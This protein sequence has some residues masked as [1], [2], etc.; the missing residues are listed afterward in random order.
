MAT[1]LLGFNPYGGGTVLDISS[2]P[3]QLYIQNEQHEQAK[4][5]ALDKYF[6]DYE[7]T[8]N[9]AGM[10]AVD[11]DV[12]LN[13]L[14]QAK[15][16]YL[17]NRDCILNPAKCGAEAQS[18]Y[19]AYLKEA[20]GVIGQSKQAA[21]KEKDLQTY[22]G[23][24]HRSGKAIDEDQ[25]FGMLD[26]SKKPIGMGYQEPDI[27]SIQPY[28][29]HNPMNLLSKIN[30]L[31][32]IEGAAQAVP[33]TKTTYQDVSP[34]MLDKN[35]AKT[36]AYSELGDVGYR[37]FIE[38]LAKDPSETARLNQIHPLPS[39]DNPNYLNELSY[40]HIL[41]QAPDSYK[42]SEVK[43]TE[44]EKTKLALARQKGS[45]TLENAQNTLNY[46]NGGLSLLQGDGDSDAANNYFNYWKSQ[47]KGELGGTVGFDKIKKVSPGV[48]QFDYKIPKDGVAIPS[49]TVIDVN[50]PAAKNQLYALH[51]QFLGSNPKAEG[52]LLPKGMPKPSAKTKTWAER[53]AEL[54]NKK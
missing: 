31:K 9:P 11:Q 21:A 18:T 53:Q 41:S 19:N 49:S 45:S 6:M 48:W 54:K 16:F 43:L 14:G 30:S 5:E 1:G 23:Q 44:A 24:V 3:T 17:Q 12:F 40:A 26:N 33:L 28:T 15:K 47:G 52:A 22:I 7:R 38:K 2:K 32:R 37:K 10:R 51:Q 35:E 8:L 50:N 29:P 39:R 27:A 20:Q 34:L 25:V 36:L 4:R 42:R 46:I 13:K